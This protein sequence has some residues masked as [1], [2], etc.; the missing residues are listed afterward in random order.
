[1]KAL[2]RRLL[3]ISILEWRRWWE[4]ISILEWRRWS[5]SIRQTHAQL[6]LL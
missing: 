6:R 2:M 3:V 4:V 5:N 1:M